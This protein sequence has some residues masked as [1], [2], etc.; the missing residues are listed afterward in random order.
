MTLE[1]FNTKLAGEFIRVTLQVDHCRPPPKTVTHAM[2]IMMTAMAYDFALS[3]VV[4][5][6]FI[7]KT[8]VTSGILF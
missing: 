1:L 3:Y 2:T 4:S 6:V 8:I 7:G 5:S